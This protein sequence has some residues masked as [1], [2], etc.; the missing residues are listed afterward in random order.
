MRP[1]GAWWTFLSNLIRPRT[2][3]RRHSGVSPPSTLPPHGPKKERK[4]RNEK[5]RENKKHS[6]YSPGPP[7]SPDSPSQSPSPAA[8]PGLQLNLIQV[9]LLGLRP[10]A[11]P[12]IRPTLVSVKNSNKAG[13]ARSSRKSRRVD[14]TLGV[15]HSQ[16]FSTLSHIFLISGVQ[17]RHLAKRW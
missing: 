17:R 6:K 4:E 12:G 8:G 13:V 11:R 3:S 2:S 16:S 7:S 1:G 15:S 9:L 5:K 14:G 10:E